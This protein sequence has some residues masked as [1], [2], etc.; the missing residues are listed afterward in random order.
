M[1][2]TSKK[3]YRITRSEDFVDKIIELCKGDRYIICYETGS[4]TEKPHFHLY[5]EMS[6]IRS[7]NWGR[8]FKSWREKYNIVGNEDYSTFRPKCKEVKS[9]SYLLKGDSEVDVP[10]IWSN[11]L[12][13]QDVIDGHKLF[14]EEKLKSEEKKERKSTAFLPIVL[15]Q[16]YAWRKTVKLDGCLRSEEKVVEWLVTT[17]LDHQKLFDSNVIVKYRNYLMSI[18]DKRYMVDK[19]QGICLGRY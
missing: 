17:F 4:I 13:E 18:V 15:E 10:K 1:S 16:F 19:L 8:E 5:I 9:Y 12:T 6:Q 11:F 3:G 7:K 2:D 14:W